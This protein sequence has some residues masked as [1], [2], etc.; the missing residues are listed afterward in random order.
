M[1]LGSIRRP[2][3]ADSYKDPARS[4]HARARLVEPRLQ[5]VE[6]AEIFRDLGSERVAG[7]SATGAH[8]LPEHRVV[9]VAAEVVAHGGANQLGQR[10]KFRQHLLDRPR[11]DL[12][13]VLG[14]RI[15]VA[16]ISTV[17]PIMM[18]FPSSWHRCA[19][20]ASWW[21]MEEEGP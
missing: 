7:L 1:G 16:D 19:V 18:D 5:R 20:R 17:M 4:E 14:N 2:G 6:T 10:G 12:W 21:H 9:G 15:E 3:P 11:R 8:D 13:M